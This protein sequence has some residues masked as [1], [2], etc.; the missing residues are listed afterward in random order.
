MYVYQFTF[1][2]AKWIWRGTNQGGVLLRHSRW[3]HVEDQSFLHAAGYEPIGLAQPMNHYI[4][5]IKTAKLMFVEI[6]LGPHLR[7]RTSAY[8][9]HTCSRYCFIVMA[10]DQTVRNRS[11][12]YKHACTCS[13]YLNQQ[14]SHIW[15]HF[16]M[17]SINVTRSK[18]TNVKSQTNCT[19]VSISNA[20]SNAKITDCQHNVTYVRVRL[21][22]KTVLYII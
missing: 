7:F 17:L 8:Y 11:T 2:A 4:E 10:I 1:T 15:T 6:G 16:L 14:Q 22:S 3:F 12:W 18:E 20:S 9:Q 5:Y 21:L 13:D 19:L